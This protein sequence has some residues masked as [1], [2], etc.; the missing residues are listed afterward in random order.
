MKTSHKR[1][2]KDRELIE[3]V[4]KYAGN[5]VI[6][7]NRPKLHRIRRIIITSPQD[8]FPIEELTFKKYIKGII[9]K[10]R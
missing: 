8:L 6:P 4:K 1:S 10:I 5:L 2:L 3:F 7:F 9:K